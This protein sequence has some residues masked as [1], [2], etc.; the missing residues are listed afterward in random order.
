KGEEDPKA[1]NEDSARDAAPADAAQGAAR[2]VMLGDEM[3]ILDMVR[4]LHGYASSGMVCV[5]RS[6]PLEGP[7]STIFP[8]RK[9]RVPTRFPTI[10]LSV[11]CLRGRR[12]HVPPCRRCCQP[13]RCL[14]GDRSRTQV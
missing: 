1:D 7:V 11:L 13:A 2:S 9:P 10:P 5:S 3:Q 14:A 6:Y 4:H 8:P 12:H